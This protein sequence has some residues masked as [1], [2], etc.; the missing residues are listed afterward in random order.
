MTGD[1]MRGVEIIAVGGEILR[2]AVRELNSSV[3]SRELARIGHAPSRVTIVPDA[4]GR[5]EREIR[6][7]VER[8]SFVVVTGGLGPTVDDVTTEAAIRALGG[9]SEVREEIAAL[10]AERFR[11]LGRSMPAAYRARVR[12]PRGATVLPNTVGAAVGLRVSGQAFDLFLLPGVPEEMKEMFERSVRP[13]IARSGIDPM[14]RLGTCGLTETELEERL[15]R[16]LSN[17]EMGRLSIISQPAGVDLYVPADLRPDG[18]VDA[19]ETALG[20]HCYTT[21][22]ASLEEVVLGLC[23]DRRIR[24]ATAESVTGGLLAS[25]LVSVPGASAVLL[26]G[27]VTYSNESKSGRLGVDGALI[28]EHGAV[29]AAVCVA[30]ARGARDRSGADIALSTTGVAGPA[31]G[32][33]DKPVGLCYVGLDAAGASFCRTL[34]LPGSREMVR[35][36]TVYRALDLLRLHLIG[37]DDRVLPYRI[38]DARKEGKT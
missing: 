36:R 32:S 4:V 30:M 5:I 15:D 31:G 27:F 1:P 11:A 34:R 14:R 26:E 35:M 24:L 12:V 9:E 18:A 8:S 13:V 25:T 10:V 6:A 23:A 16:V 29:S 19:I 22:D 37:A 2:G 28:R 17:A 20:D 38:V 21:G 7:A 33:A 3:L